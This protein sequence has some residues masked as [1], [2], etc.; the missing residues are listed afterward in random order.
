MTELRYL[1]M[2]LLLAMLAWSRSASAQTEQPCVP[3]PTAPCTSWELDEFQIAESPEAFAARSCRLPCRYECG[4]TECRG[5][6]CFISDQLVQAGWWFSTLQGS[7]AKVAQ[8]Q[9]LQSSPFWSIDSLTSNGCTTTDLFA[10][11]LDREASD[12]F[13]RAFQP[14]FD[15]DVSYQRYIRHV[16]PVHFFHAGPQDAEPVTAEGEDDASGADQFLVE[17]LS[18]GQDYAIRVQQLKADF[19]GK[20]TK[21]AKW[22]L[23][24]WSMRKSGERQTFALSNSYSPP[25][26]AEA[27]QAC[28]LQSQRQEIDWRTVDIE[29]GVEARFGPVTVSFSLPI[30]SF[31]QSDQYMTR[32][33]NP[34]PENYNDEAIPPQLGSENFPEGVRYPHSYVPETFTQIRKL[35]VHV[36]LSECRQ[37]YASLYHGSTDNRHRDTRRNFSGADLRLTDRTVPGLTWTG[38]AKL[39]H[40]DNPMPTELISGET[41]E[42]DRFDESVRP[43]PEKDSHDYG[44]CG[45]DPTASSCVLG[46]DGI[47]DFFASDA[48]VEPVDYSRTTIGIN[49]RWR[50]FRH[51]CSWKRGLRCYGRYEYRLLHRQ[52]AEFE[53]AVARGETIVSDQTETH[54]H[55]MQ[56]GLSQRWSMT[57]DSFVRYRTWFE[58]D[59]LYGI[60]ETNGTTNSSLPTHADI[61]EIGGTWSPSDC[62]LASGRIG[63]ENREHNSAIARFDEWDFPLTLT[64]WYA[65]SCVLSFSA[66][67]MYGS[68]RIRQAIT[69]G[70]DLVGEEE[71][72][73]A[74]RLWRYNARS[75]VF[76]LGGVYRWTPRW[77]WR[78]DVQY[79]RGDNGIES[80]IFDD[81]LVWPE[82]AN[83]VRTDRHSLRVSAGLDY[84]LGRGVSSYLR[85]NYLD[86]ED[87]ITSVNSG[88]A[89]LLLAGLTGRY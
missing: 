13:V 25:G 23:H 73:P 77:T 58:S 50:P 3:V 87:A 59:P 81:P 74:T 11:G 17:D 71:Y 9:D 45:C 6:W 84:T 83:V 24:V 35:K 26:A 1:T 44:G 20:L 31:R 61:V 56:L 7:P 80:T 79:I 16:E 39:N 33:Y 15:A 55:L 46:A 38:Y 42:F 12:V 70:D 57:L 19:H 82:I 72:A 40:Q 63:I 49:G 60:R 67:Y 32:V 18:V 22:R 86:Y 21:N 34:P 4:P 2:G 36:Q 14:E 53:A 65:P 75:H 30:R 47:A 51:D 89:H 69:L 43:C 41:L 76:A 27:C 5:E 78:G 48:L 88:T 29:P 85:Y 8:Y 52:H 66:G 28:H 10:A 37:L 54:R 68:N 62:L 64:L